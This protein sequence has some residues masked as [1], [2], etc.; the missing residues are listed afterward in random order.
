MA[1]CLASPAWSTACWMRERFSVVNGH[2]SWHRLNIGAST[3]V[4]PRKLA[5]VVGTLC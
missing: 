2:T 1:T 5:S 4:L 3:T